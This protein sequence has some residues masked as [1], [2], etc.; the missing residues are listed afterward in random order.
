[1]PPTPP[2]SSAPPIRRDGVALHRQV[3]LI[4]K[5]RLLNHSDAAGTALPSEEA[6]CAEFGVARI[7][8]RRAL[9]S[10]REEGLVQSRQGK[11]SFA[12][13]PALPRAPAATLIGELQRTSDS[14]RARL[15]S[16]GMVAAP[17]T[18]QRWLTLEPGA[19]VQRS[20]RVRSR[21]RTPLLLVTVYLVE[22]I[23]RGISRQQLQAGPLL[24]LLQGMGLRYGR[25]QQEIHA[26]LADPAKAHV[27]K[28]PVGAALGQ[29]TRVMT[30]EALKPVQ[31]SQ[32]QFV[33]ERTRF[34]SVLQPGDLDSAQ[35]GE[36]VHL[37]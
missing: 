23:G 6:L 7:T 32:V 35:A 2:L 9:T 37:I 21:G 13:A 4:L 24:P 11:G 8:L 30:D 28:V 22:S 3:Y 31:V 27:L 16:F 5:D 10:L 15:L 14:T 17:A 29:L 25:V 33:P 36:L 12:A 1:M 20:V 26:I 18:V 19:L 34:V